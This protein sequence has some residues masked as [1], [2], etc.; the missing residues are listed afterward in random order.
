MRRSGYDLKLLEAQRD[1]HENK[2]MEG[3]GMGNQENMQGKWVD[4]NKDEILE[5]NRKR[6][7]PLRKYAFKLNWGRMNFNT[8]VQE[9]YYLLSVTG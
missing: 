1:F 8:R 5:S 4:P 3:M 7:I 2:S 6:A 9:I